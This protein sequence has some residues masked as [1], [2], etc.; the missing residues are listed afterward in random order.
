MKIIFLFC[1]IFFLFPASVNAATYYVSP[2]GADTNPGSFAQPWLNPQ[3]AFNTLIAGDTVYFRGGTYQG[4][5]TG[6]KF[7][8]SGTQEQ[9]I[10]VANYPGEQVIFRML[11]AA[12]DSN[13]FKCFI[14]PR[15]PISWQTVKA[16]YIHIIG[17]DVIPQTLPDGTLSN[18]GIIMLGEE[19]AQAAA[20]N[21]ASCDQWEVAGVDFIKVAN[22][23]FTRKF[24]WGE[25]VDYSPDYWYV[26][27]NR[28]HTFYRESGM[29]FNGSHNRIENNEIYKVTNRKDTE[30]GCTL[31][32]LLGNNNIVRHNTLNGKGT[33]VTCNGL[34]FEWDLS[35]ANLIE[36]NTIQ[37]VATGIDIGGGDNNTIVGNI[38]RG[39]SGTTRPGVLVRSYENT[40]AWPCNDYPNSGFSA[41]TILPPNNPSHP[42][43]QYYFPHDCRSKNNKILGNTITGFTQP[44][45]MINLQEP[46]NI[47]SETPTSPSPSPTPSLPAGKAGDANGDNKVDG[48]DY[49]VWLTHYNQSVTGAA[50]GN[51]DNFGKVD[52]EDYKIWLNN[53]KK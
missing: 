26:H 52:D 50:N 20:I 11:S 40:T 23:I 49:V 48:I 47:Y 1:C 33:T 25:N 34:L 41:E 24:N 12:N 19:G 4:I 35:D 10:T 39:Q 13:I 42:D 38:L 37:E 45:H 32:N 53:Y 6:W 44:F 7:K 27:D 22:G 28:V 30:Y 8:Y 43:Y 29:Q 9:P 16:D 31:L 18:K 3:K 14:N 15:D 36:N 51:F 21:I 17:T 5:K 46:S 2:S